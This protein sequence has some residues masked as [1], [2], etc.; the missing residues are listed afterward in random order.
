MMPES[1]RTA[2]E[3]CKIRVGNNNKEAAMRCIFNKRIIMA[4]ALP[5]LLLSTAVAHADSTLPLRKPGLWQTTMT[6]KMTMNGMAMPNGMPGG[7]APIVTAMCSDAATDAKEMQRMAGGPGHCSQFTVTHDGDT[8]TMDGTCAAP[9]G[10][11][12]MTTHAVITK[13]SDTAFHIVSQTTST[14]VSGSMVGESVWAGACPAGVA[15]GDY[16]AMAGGQF[17]KRGNMM[18][19]AP[20]AMPPPQ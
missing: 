1:L 4:A 19:M 10:G 7:G 18:N 2:A 3:P 16:G 9:M 11:G 15:P 8:Y 6:M 5:A 17:V 14:A 12:A 20:P 13:E